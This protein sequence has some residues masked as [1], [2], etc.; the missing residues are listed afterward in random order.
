MAMPRKID[1][2]EIGLLVGFCFYQLVVFSLFFDFGGQQIQE[3]QSSTQTLLRLSS[4]VVLGSVLLACSLN[5]RLAAIMLKKGIAIGAAVALLACYALSAFAGTESVT[6]TMVLFVCAIL[7]G[8]GTAVLG[9]YWM[10]CFYESAFRSIIISIVI[11]VC[12]EAALF[13]VSLLSPN[14][15][16]IIAV[17]SAPLSV[18][19]AC[20]MRARSDAGA[21]GENESKMPAGETVF[22]TL[23]PFDKQTASENEQPQAAQTRILQIFG[24]FWGLTGIAFGFMTSISAMNELPQG[25]FPWI[26]LLACLLGVSFAISV[27]QQKGKG[28]LASPEAI[29]MVIVLAT[30]LFGSLVP[31]INLGY[32]MQWCARLIGLIGIS[33]VEAFTLLLYVVFARTMSLPYAA[34]YTV[35]AG[36]RSIGSFIGSLIGLALTLFASSLTN[37]VLIV[38]LICAAQLITAMG[39]MFSFV[40]P[41]KNAVKAPKRKS[42][43]S[44]RCK[45]LAEAYCL[46]EREV[47]VMILLAKGYS[48]SGIQEEL[49]IA[50]GTAT[51]HAHHIYKKLGIH[52][53]QELLDL[54]DGKPSANAYINPQ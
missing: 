45:A 43:I 40:P 3:Q 39:I 27:F 21:N 26:A 9:L 30:T 24:C 44:Q 12:L 35:G 17:V 18:G 4:L 37:T 41:G 6:Q 2:R 49:V 52:S 16:H 31:Q 25:I 22:A 46:T 11:M 50:K 51:T 54:V 33:L 20:A 7:S 15:W 38:A 13:G 34:V 36:S 48:I 42:S 8:F 23:F 29:L 47:E 32:D 5:K 1:W 19:C 28:K 53:R 10:Q 14:V